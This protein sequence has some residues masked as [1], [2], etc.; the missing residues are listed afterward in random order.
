MKH[1]SIILAISVVLAT[2][3]CS[4]DPTKGT[5]SAPTAPSKPRLTASNLPKDASTVCVS[6]VTQ[7]D[8]LTNGLNG[9][10]DGQREQKMTSLDALIE[11]SCY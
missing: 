11:D 7:R 1:R 4:D 5:A 2:G 3:S 8:Q 6:A 10:T 9:L